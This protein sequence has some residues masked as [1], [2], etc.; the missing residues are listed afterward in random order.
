MEDKREI[1]TNLPHDG[2][3][4]SSR[5]VP[6]TIYHETSQGPDAFQLNRLVLNIFLLLFFA[7]PKCAHT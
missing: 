4:N 3:T 7:E 5:L 6:T 1:Q 2:G